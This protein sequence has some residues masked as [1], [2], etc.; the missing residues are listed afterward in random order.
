MVVS[1][2]A[3]FTAMDE[4][5]VTPIVAILFRKWTFRERD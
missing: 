5:Q 3:S 1:E 4:L 2:L